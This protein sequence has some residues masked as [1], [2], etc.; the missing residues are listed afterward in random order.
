MDEEKVVTVEPNLGYFK[1][2]DDFGSCL[3]ST[4]GD[5]VEALR[6]HSEGLKEDAQTLSKIADAL[7]GISATAFGDTHVITIDMP[8]NVANK[9]LEDGLAHKDI[10]EEDDEDNEDEDDGEDMDEEEEEL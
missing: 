1:R 5:V 8:E 2:G 9:L 10:F 6:L 3:E 7:E 4:K